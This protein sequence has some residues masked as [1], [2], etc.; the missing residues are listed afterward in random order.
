VW[1]SGET[2]SPLRIR[3]TPLRTVYLKGGSGYF[4]DGYWGHGIDHGGLV[5][6]GVTHDVGSP[7]GR[8]ALCWL[9][10]TLS[11]YEASDGSVGYG[12]YENMCVGVY[13]P[14]GFDDAASVAP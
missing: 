14:A 11:R 8:A 6:E 12:M 1:F 7:A 13:K 2:G 4:Y 3:V 10:E 9:N 5:I